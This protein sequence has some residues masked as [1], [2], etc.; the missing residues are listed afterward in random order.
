MRRSRLVALAAPAV[1]AALVAGVAAAGHR[2]QSSQQVAADF[3]AG[4][5]TKTHT[6]TCVGADGTYQDTTA[7]YTGAA[8]SGD[9]RL[10]GALT[11]RAHS[12]VNTATGVGWAE[13]S[14][15]VRGA[16]AG[17]HGTLH[18]ALAG[19]QA[20]G[21][22]VGKADHA[23]GKLVASVSS[24]FTQGGGF[25]SGKLGSGSANGAGVVF[26]HGT[27]TKQKNLT[28]TA[29]FKVKLSA[30]QVV[31][32]V[33]GLRAEASG[34]LTLDLARDA[35]G[36]V[37]GGTA[38]FYVN[39]RFPAAVTITGL[40]LH[41]GAR[42]STGGGVL[43]AGTGTFADADGRGNVTK[44]V[45]GVSATLAQALLADPRGYYLE[46]ATS[47]HASGA[48]RAQLGGFSRR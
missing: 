24:L 3:A 5:V 43:D 38:V 26:S 10:N 46:L 27:C 32:P 30:K 45:A 37:T 29:I 17:A 36:T 12:V 47:D 22:V 48:L 18:A 35:S 21:A 41:Q 16:G 23:E 6:R 14:F 40:A 33:S 4:S 39:Y 25:A 34:S 7:T 8:T 15:R 13:G 31:P 1:V 42:G 9:A 11:I 20:V 28:A 2:S 19:G 44:V